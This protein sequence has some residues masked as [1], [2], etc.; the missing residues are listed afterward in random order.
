MRIGHL[1][2]LS[3]RAWPLGEQIGNVELSG[4]EYYIAVTRCPT[5][6]AINEFAGE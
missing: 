6:R 3:G 2:Q 4:H 5:I 1:R